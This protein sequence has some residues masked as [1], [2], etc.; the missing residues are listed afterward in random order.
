MQRREFLKKI[1]AGTAGALTLSTMPFLHTSCASGAEKPNIIVILCDDLGY[2]DI[3]CYGGEIDTPNLDAMAESGVKFTQ[4]YNAAR[5]CPTRASILTGLYPHQAGVGHMD[6]DHGFPAYQGYLNENCV[7]I[8]DVMQS[9]GYETCASGKWHTGAEDGSRPMQRGFDR[10]YGLLYGACNYFKPPEGEIWE[11]DEPTEVPKDGSYYTT[12]AFTDHAVNF[13]G[14]TGD[15][16]DPFFLYLAYTAPH[17]PLQAWPEDIEKYRG[18]YMQGWDQLREERYQRLIDLDMIDPEW[19]LSPRDDRNGPWED[20]TDEEKDWRDHLMAIY[21]AMVDNMDQ[22]IGRV[23]DKLKETGQYENTLIFFVSDNGACPYPNAM[24]DEPVYD[25]SGDLIVPG[26]PDAEY[27]YG[28]EWA[29]AGNTPFRKYKQ[30]TH[31]GG[32][33][34]PFIVHWPAAR[35]EGLLTHQKGHII[36]V[37]ATCVDVAGAQYPSEHEGNQIHPMEGISLLPII[38]GNQREG[39]EYIC[40]EHKGN[41]GILKDD[42][43][44]VSYH[45]TQRGITDEESETAGWELYN[46]AADRTELNDL[47]DEEP[48]RVAELEKLYQA[49]ADRVGVLPWSQVTG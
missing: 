13:I 1:S 39:H 8:A 4:F 25:D 30:F 22:N 46:L 15:T 5:C 45:P 47:I 27:A 32:T 20:L 48:E 21:A 16:E 2:S 33:A 3:G 6:S 28:W 18:K 43:K 19:E 37:M 31:E 7:S 12:D 9:A 23:L 10:Y 34:T 49:W 11:G 38:Q 17:Y 29:N 14:D 36:D 41:Q 24:G 26:G 40:W 42:W 44:L 35:Q